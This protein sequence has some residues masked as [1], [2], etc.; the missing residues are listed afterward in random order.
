M[1]KEELIKYLE[2]LPTGCN[3]VWQGVAVHPGGRYEFMRTDI[4]LLYREGYNMLEVRCG[5]E[6]LS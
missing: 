2:K 1:I 4:E 3:V 5:T 6:K